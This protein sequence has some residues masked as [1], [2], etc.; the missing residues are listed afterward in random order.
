MKKSS[1]MIGWLKESKF[2]IKTPVNHMF[3]VRPTDVCKRNGGEQTISD[4]C[5]EIEQ[6]IS[7]ERSCNSSDDVQ[8]W[9]LWNYY[10]SQGD[11]RCVFTQMP[12]LDNGLVYNQPCSAEQLAK[13]K[14]LLREYES[15]RKD[16]HSGRI[17]A[18]DGVLSW[19]HYGTG[20]QWT[21]F[22]YLQS[23]RNDYAE[24]L[25][26]LCYAGHEDWRIPTIPEIR[27][28]LSA[29]KEMLGV[30]QHPLA[31]SLPTAMPLPVEQ[32]PNIHPSAD[33]LKGYYVFKKETTVRT[34]TRYNRSDERIDDGGHY[35]GKFIAVRGERK[36]QR[37]FQT[38][39]AGT[40]LQWTEKNMTLVEQGQLPGSSRGWKNLERLML[41]G[42]HFKNEDYIAACAAMTFLEKLKEIWLTIDESFHEIP[43]PLY[44][45]SQIKKLHVWNKNTGVKDVEKWSITHISSDIQKTI[46]LE[47]IT[48]DWQIDLTKVPDEIFDLP[49]L[50]SLR[51][52]GC[53]GLILS[54]K[55][56]IK[57]CELAKAGVY[58]D[59]PP[60]KLHMESCRMML[61]KAVKDNGGEIDWNT[62]KSV[63]ENGTEK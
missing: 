42:E 31:D 39:W 4:L 24:L 23:S 5:F 25:N 33:S 14:K 55:Q 11:M 59:I 37:N 44:N 27:A 47:D 29:D 49:N 38:A 15:V 43:C 45:L 30:E 2:A 21:T 62:M 3:W 1:Q 7:R 35:T 18:T 61:I 60:L 19:I 36:L 46:S 54:E 17:L 26:E 51:L 8:D 6:Q 16:H 63:F 32:T 20:L 22:S 50:T 28:M 57:I 34:G 40:L 58:I 9:Y 48:L 10:P 52:G 12:P 41:R 56:V 13:I 53:W